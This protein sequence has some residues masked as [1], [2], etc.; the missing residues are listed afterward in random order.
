MY[1]HD[2][3]LYHDA[4]AILRVQTPRGRSEGR[5]TAHHSPPIA[6]ID[7]V[8]ATTTNSLPSSSSLWMKS[9]SAFT[10]WRD[11]AEDSQRRTLSAETLR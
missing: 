10:T 7:G 9:L 2:Y 11:T 4:P 5:W 8:Q 3:P 1:P 6:V